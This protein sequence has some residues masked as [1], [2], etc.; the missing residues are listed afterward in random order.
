M[1]LLQALLETLI[2]REARGDHVPLQ[3]LL[4]HLHRGE[5]HRGGRRGGRLPHRGGRRPQHA[6]K[7]RRGQ[8]RILASDWLTWPQY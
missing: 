3:R 1:D 6:G 4:S 2:A 8:V 5:Q 7:L